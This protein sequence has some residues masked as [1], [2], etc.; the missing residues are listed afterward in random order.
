MNRSWPLL[1][2]GVDEAGRGPLAGPVV[3]SAVILNPQRRVNG[4]ADSKVL[5][6]ER[7][8]TLAARIRERAI[9]F[10]VI[11]IDVEQID[12]LNIFHATMLGMTRA[13]GRTDAAT[14]TCADRRQSCC[15]RRSRATNVR[16]SMATRSNSASARRRFSRRS[17]ATRS[18]ANSMLCIRDTVSQGTKAIPHRS[19]SPRSN[20]W[21]L[22]RITAAVSC[23]CSRARTAGSVLRL[24]RR[25]G[26]HRLIA[27]GRKRN[28]A[29][30]A[31][32]PLP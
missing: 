31:A 7:R 11:V 13:V 6:A 28:L 12:R 17:P 15:R 8:E 9:A 2:A 20:G 27:I 32:Q 10:T 19:I 30:T 23:P 16:S 21:D 26:R 5:T 18:C 25:G 1:T 3:V 4:L 29:C 14:G 24:R 22:A